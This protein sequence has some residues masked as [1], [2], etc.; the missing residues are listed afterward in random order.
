MK[1]LNRIARV[2]KKKAELRELAHCRV[3]DLNSEDWI[4][5][6][7]GDVMV[8]LLSPT[9]RIELKLEEHLLSVINNVSAPSIPSHLAHVLTRTGRQH[10]K[11]EPV[12]S[13][14]P[15]IRIARQFARQSGVDR[16]N[17]AM[18]Q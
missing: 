6:D 2:L 13:R 4:I 5:V 17:V 7:L 14:K 18:A 12:A 3:E 15:V 8:H 16:R 1:H 11:F 10:L 9:K